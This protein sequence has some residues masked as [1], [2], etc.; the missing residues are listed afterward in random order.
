MSTKTKQRN[1]TKL[2][3]KNMNLWSFLGV[4]QLGTTVACFLP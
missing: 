4:V 1:R 3:T 2:D